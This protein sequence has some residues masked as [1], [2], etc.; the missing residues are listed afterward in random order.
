MLNFEDLGPRH[1]AGCT[2]MNN[3]STSHIYEVTA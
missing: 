2:H 1:I 3:N